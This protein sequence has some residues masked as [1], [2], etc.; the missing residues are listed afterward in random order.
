MQMFENQVEPAKR[1]ERM[2]Q[3]LDG[4]GDVRFIPWRNESEMNVGG[5]S[6]PNG[7]NFKRARD[8]CKLPGNLWV[9]S[10]ANKDADAGT[11]I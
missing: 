11:L 10:D 4:A 5:A 6:K 1:Q 9:N 3:F 8:Y 7:I 2:A